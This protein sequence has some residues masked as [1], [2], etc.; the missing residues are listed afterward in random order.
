[1]AED[2]RKQV[3]KVVARAWLDKD[4]HAR[5]MKD[6]HAVLTEAG[7]HLKGKV[8]VHQSTDTD[9]HLVIPQRPAALDEH[10]RK[11]KEKPGTCSNDPQLCTIVPELCSVGN[12][13]A[14]PQLCT[15]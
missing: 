7:I 8:H 9:H 12:H 15:I 11:Q 4:F 1:M 3:S 6:P 10:V 5:L 2:I 13:N 14:T